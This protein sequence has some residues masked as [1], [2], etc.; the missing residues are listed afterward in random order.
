[1]TSFID[2]WLIGHIRHQR[3]PLPETNSSHLPGSHPNRKRS[4]SNHPFSG[5]SCLVQRGYLLETG[6]LKK[7]PCWDDQLDQRSTFWRIFWSPNK[8]ATPLLEI[9]KTNIAPA[10]KQSL[11]GNM[12]LQLTRHGVMGRTRIGWC[13]I[14]ISK[15]PL[16][17]DTNGT[18][19]NPSTFHRIWKLQL[20]VNV[21]YDCQKSNYRSMKLHYGKKQSRNTTITII[22]TMM[23]MKTA[24]NMMNHGDGD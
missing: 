8:D 7:T 6:C 12:Q 15:E 13:R 20:D 1:M 19:L 16:F 4:S 22:Y 17:A 5:A 10:R 9:S 23:T 24:T 11:K 14:E 21:W 2:Q 18:F 3:D